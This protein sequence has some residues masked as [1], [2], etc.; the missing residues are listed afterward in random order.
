MGLR[1]PSRRVLIDEASL[2]DLPVKKKSC[3]RYQF[4][5]VLLSCDNSSLF[6]SI[7]FDMHIMDLSSLHLAVCLHA[8]SLSHGLI[9]NIFYQQ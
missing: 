9:G 4:G 7:Y 2:S 8:L 3:L 1:I 5:L 6:Y